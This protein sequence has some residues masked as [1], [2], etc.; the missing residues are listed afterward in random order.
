MTNTDHRVVPSDACLTWRDQRF[1]FSLPNGAQSENI[2]YKY[3]LQVETRLILNFGNMSVNMGE[4]WSRSLCN[5][6]LPTTSGTTQVSTRSNVLS[7]KTAI[8]FSFIL[9]IKNSNAIWGK[10]KNALHKCIPLSS[11][12]PLS[13]LQG[14]KLDKK[15][16]SP[17]IPGD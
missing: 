11:R 16:H 9:F 10:K 6:F 4:S 15:L 17:Q 3:K 5:C 12:N 2:F 14:R 8:L 13:H 7:A 1:F